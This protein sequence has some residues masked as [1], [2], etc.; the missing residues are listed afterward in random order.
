[1]LLEAVAAAYPA[2]L[3]PGLVGVL[4]SRCATKDAAPSCKT[5]TQ[6]QS[7]EDLEKGLCWG[8]WLG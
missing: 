3:L 1:M 8:G 5:T 4:L 6:Q 7:M 2:V